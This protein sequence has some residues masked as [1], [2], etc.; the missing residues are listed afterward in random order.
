MIRMPCSIRPNAFSPARPRGRAILDFLALVLP[1]AV[2]AGCGKSGGT[3]NGAQGGSV[4]A[5]LPV[6]VATVQ[7]QPAP[8]ALHAIGTVEPYAS[9]TI[10]PQVDGQ[11]IEVRF[12]EGQEVKAGD[13]LLQ[14][15]P[16]PFEAA[17]QLAQADLARDQ[18]LARDAQREA[19]RIA[20]LYAKG[21]AADREYSQTQADAEAKAAQVKADE[22]AVASA[23]LELAYCTIRSPL[24]GRIGARLADPGNVVKINETELAVINQVHPI[25]VSFSLAERHLATIREHMASGPLAVEVRV[26][27]SDGPVERG[28]LTFVDNQVDPTTGMIRLKG[29]FANEHG[30][31]WPGQYVD[32]ALILVVRPSAIVV[33]TQA[34]QTGPQGLF[35][36]VVDN[37][38]KVEMRSV[39]IGDAL[40]GVSVVESGLKPGE[41]VVIDGQLRLTAGAKVTLIHGAAHGTTSPAQAGTASRPGDGA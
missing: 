9:V 4:G 5:A 24:D 22:A 27:Q 30:R 17:L 14:I 19:R 35:V 11:L 37:H 2:V 32:V 18:A 40:E 6:R 13:I 15:D 34:V 36:F 33:P 21:S 20:G 25:Y 23:E 28:E 39:S 8:L 29:T 7:T 12:A 38:Q 3:T 31:L 16:R 26:P 10:K 1:L 41:Q